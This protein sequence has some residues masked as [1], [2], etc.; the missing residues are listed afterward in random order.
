MI[1]EALCCSRTTIF[2]KKYRVSDDTENVLPRRTALPLGFGDIFFSD[3]EV[4]DFSGFVHVD[5]DEGP[6]LG[7]PQTSL[8][9]TLV[10]QGGFIF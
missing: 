4:V 3:Q 1:G 6:R 8:F 9:V 10:D 5:L 7:Q 2:K